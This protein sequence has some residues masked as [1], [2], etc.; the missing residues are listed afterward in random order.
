MCEKVVEGVKK[1]AKEVIGEN[2]GS[3]SKDKQT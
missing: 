3:I 1:V 2:R